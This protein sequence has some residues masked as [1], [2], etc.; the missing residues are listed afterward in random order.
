LFA[1]IKETVVCDA[2]GRITSTAQ[3]DLDIPAAFVVNFV[4]DLQISTAL[5][6]ALVPTKIAA[7][8]AAIKQE[9][10]WPAARGR[11]ILCSSLNTVES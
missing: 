7:G 5:V 11:F 10:S 4:P 2:A 8:F 6:L 3:G 1:V 9:T